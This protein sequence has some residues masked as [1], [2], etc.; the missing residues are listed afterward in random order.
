MV[1]YG[2]SDIPLSAYM[3]LVCPEL[4]Y[5]AVAKSVFDLRPFYNRR[6]SDE[7]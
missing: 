5:S 4:K 6:V 7:R 1:P 3:W 2:M